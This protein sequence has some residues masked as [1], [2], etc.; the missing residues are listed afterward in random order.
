MKRHSAPLGM[1]DARG[2][3]LIELMVSLTIGLILMVAVISAYLG[4]AGASRMAEAQG[5]MNEDGQAAL[6]IL[7]EQVRMAGAN[8]LQSAYTTSQPNSNFASNPVY[9]TGTSYIAV[10][11]CDGTFTDIKTATSTLVLSCT[12]GTNTDRDSIAVSYE[13]DVYNTAPTTA[14]PPVPTDCLGQGLPIPPFNGA[15]TVSNGTT[16]STIAVPVYKVAD[17]RFFIGTSTT[18]IT[19]SL[20]CQGNG[21]FNNAQPLVENVEDMQIL[22]GTSSLPVGSTKTVAGYLTAN[23]VVSDTALNPMTLAERWSRVSTVRICVLVRS[24]QPIVSDLA[25]AQYV[26]CDGTVETNPPDRRL[27]RAYTTTVMMRNAT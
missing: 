7:A 26:K 27:R 23:Q 4:S 6:A 16:T 3:S 15:A 11:G 20:Y 9:G 18:I 8:P 13:A 1:N 25:S 2:F 17:N 12:A 19:P 5:R 14:T 10:R 24:E 22:Y 21:S